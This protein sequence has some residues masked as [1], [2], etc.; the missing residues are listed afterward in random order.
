MAITYIETD[1]GKLA[2]EVEGQGPLVICSPG[3]GDTREAYAPMAAQLVAAG[4]R[5]A[6][7]DLRGH[8]DSTANFNRYGDE[9]T[10]DDYLTIIQTLGADRAVLAG[11]SMSAA[12]AYIAAGKQPDKIAG[13]VLIGAFLRNGGSKMM[14]YVL[15]MALLQPWG[16]TVWRSYASGLWPGL[17]EKAAAERAA[18]T[19][20][21]LTRPGRWSAFRSTVAGC[22]HT[23]V[24]P[25]LGKVKVPGLV[26]IGES[27]PD[28]S[29]PLEEAKWVASNFEDVETIAVTG[30]GHA[31]QFENPDVVT[32]GVISFLSKITF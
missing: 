26:V 8:G 6:R 27:D 20:A 2:V 29:Q 16:P 13:L 9:A 21:M 32:P 22:D 28:W 23:V 1:G 24:E 3:M 7:V 31:P 19:T 10:A 30:A 17:G 4:Y 18:T 25:Y 11:A 12:A 5:V 15:R 14:L